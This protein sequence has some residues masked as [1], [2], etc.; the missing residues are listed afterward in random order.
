MARLEH[1]AIVPVYDFGETSE[2]QLYFVMSFVNG[3]DVH[4]MVQSKGRLPP[5]HAL[6]I[7]AHVCDALT[8]AH[9]HGVIHRDIK[10]SNVLI[11]MEGQVKVADFGLAKVDDPSQSSG[12]TKTGLAMGTPDYVAPETLTLGMIV[13]GRAD[14]YAVGVMLYQML[15]GNVPRGMFTMPSVMIGSD[16]RFDAIIAKAMKYDREE[17][18]LTAT[19]LRRDL[20][21]ILT[22]PLVQ[23]GGQSSAAIPMQACHGVKQGNPVAPQLESSPKRH[24][25]EKAKTP[26]YIGA[27]AAAA[28]VVIALYAFI[29]G[30]NDKPEPSPTKTTLDIKM[31]NESSPVA[32]QLES[33]PKTTPTDNATKPDS[34]A[35]TSSSE[36][37]GDEPK[38]GTTLPPAITTASK[39]AKP[40]EK[41]PPGKWVKVLT[42]FDELPENLRSPD[43]GVKFQDGWLN[44]E[45]P[46]AWNLSPGQLGANHAIRVRIKPGKGHTSLTIRKPSIE[47]I[48]GYQIQEKGDS[49]V[50]GV[51]ALP[52]AQGAPLVLEGT[53]PRPS[54]TD[55][56]VMELG[57][58]GNRLVT[59]VE[60]SVLSKA[61]EQPKQG[62]GVSIF[63]QKEAIR[64]IEV[65]NLDGIPEAEALKI[66]GVDEKGNDLRQKPAAVASTSPSPT[67]TTTAPIS[68]AAPAAFPPGQWVKVFTKFEDLPER[69]RKPDSGVKIENGKLIIA[70]R[71]SQS[72]KFPTEFSNVGLRLKQA[73]NSPE[74]QVRLSKSDTTDIRLLARPSGDEVSCMIWKPGA[75]NGLGNLEAPR[76][77]ERTLELVVVGRRVVA[78]V[79]DQIFSAEL[80]TGEMIGPFNPEIFFNNSSVR[81]IEVINLDGIPEAEALRILGIDEKGNNTR[82]AALATEKQAMEQ[83]QVAQA[84]AGI[85]ELAAL[86]EQFKKLT[87]ER[88]TAPFEADLAKLNSG[89]LGGIDR[90]IAE[91]R[92]KG[93]LD[94]VLALEEEKKFVVASSSGT[95]SQGPDG[96][97]LPTEAF[98]GDV[99]ATD[100]ETTP[101]TLKG[102]RQIYREAFAKLDA[103]RAANLK[104]LTDP[105]SIRLKQLESTLTQANRIEHAKTVREYRENLGEGVTTDESTDAPA[106]STLNGGTAAKM[107]VADKGARTPASKLSPEEIVKW[108]LSRQGKVTIDKSGQKTTIE[109]GISIPSGSFKITRVDFLKTKDPRDPI[110]DSELENLSGLKEMQELHLQGRSGFT[111]SFLASLVASRDLVHLNISESSFQPE[112]MTSL[113]LFPNLT[114]I[115]VAGGR[116][117]E[118]L[119]S[120]PPLRKLG[121]LAIHGVPTPEMLQSLTKHPEL[122]DLKC[123]SRDWKV[124]HFRAM[125]GI[126]TL[127][128]LEL[129]S[130]PLEPET[131]VILAPL[132]KL[133]SV[134]I[135]VNIKA[136][137]LSGLEALKNLKRIALSADSVTGDVEGLVGKLPL[138]RSLEKVELQ[139]GTAEDP[140]LIKAVE[141][142]QKA[143]SKAKVVLRRP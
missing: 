132:T 35:S 57:I 30:K 108:V 2:G 96:V 105:L 44:F 63:C 11:N 110:P 77:L 80:P 140:K 59:R 33:K 115:R 122:T 127:T 143:L 93:N 103:T 64:D 19:D 38:P 92:G 142:I 42:S 41:F 107:E 104:L 117:A 137:Q 39:P 18:Y 84:A 25:P 136:G 8:Y 9:A 10:P 139:T 134:Y 12:L 22:T 87:A 5:E 100:T 3:T 50:R 29:G 101:A 74:T 82:A 79:N 123:I 75:G 58:V 47:V 109:A 72:I 114:N 89:Y 81:D 37:S 111:G 99:P 130:L 70:A 73:P 34:T 94:G 126:K 66:L 95:R 102:L 7:T 121:S 76:V 14:L 69:L 52:R 17:R 48:D 27:G 116:V 53:W 32:P 85:P 133:E 131:F 138:F 124:E 49:K 20:D 21:V 56:S 24:D 4:Q 15:T 65:I 45:K 141:V 106:R 83:K 60:A 54:A 113:S 90:N 61:I 88:V 86:D 118:A 98:T 26:R 51:A 36:L 62:T 119:S 31:P 23:A 129:Q 67:A 40:A 91:E 13:D 128:S 135:P 112:H 1:P 16:P 43:S 55:S 68:N 78:R 28:A 97:R 120:L 6:A 71:S 46:G 125:A